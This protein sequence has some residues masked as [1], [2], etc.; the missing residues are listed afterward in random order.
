MP[1]VAMY[2][3]SLTRGGAERVMVN[4]AE[5]LFARG[6]KVTL[7]TTY[8]GDDEYDVPHG[9]WR[10]ADGGSDAQ[11]DG[12]R[13]AA[14][15]TNDRPVTVSFA[16]GPGD[17]DISEYGIPGSETRIGRVFSGVSSAEAGSRPAAFMKRKKRLEE[18]W[19]KLR[20]D[21]ILSFIGKNNIMALM[22]ARRYGIPVVVSVRAVPELEYPGRLM[23]TAAGILFP[24][25]SA[26]VV[27]TEKAAE[28]FPEKVRRIAVVVPNAVSREFTEDTVS[29]ETKEREA[30]IAAAGRMDANKRF[31]LLLG[32]FA[33]I[34]QKEDGEE[35]KYRL[36]LYGDGEDRK[37]LEKLA[38]ELGIAGRTDFMGYRKDIAKQ[39]RNAGMY[40]LMS[41]TEGMP[42]T[43]IEAMCLGVPSIATDC[44][45]GGI[46][47]LVTDGENA[48]VIPVGDRE[49]LA[50]A[51][52]RIMGDP[53]LA[54]K[55]SGNGRKMREKYDP[56]NV[57][58][59]WESLLRK[60][61][62]R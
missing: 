22:T 27:Q 60:A 54:A 14:L 26:V 51:M 36:L 1:H 19:Q 30:T 25:A 55:L 5:E 46:G 43:L 28:F 52:R 29:V 34:I 35:N 56:A 40:C 50:A 12:T 33:D 45:P 57:T 24:R 18:I 23:R 53:A 44:V 62:E 41:D 47:Q 61:V 8:L 4:L 16:G 11:A 17:K 37:K 32:A 6:W 39:L 48:L 7:V 10:S 58:D 13:I 9:C 2:I 59:V 38:E 49:A 31:D 20:P 15:D 42:N 3:G 21:V